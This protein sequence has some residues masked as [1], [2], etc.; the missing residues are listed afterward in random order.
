LCLK[1][2]WDKSHANVHKT[3]PK[4]YPGYFSTDGYN[5][6]SFS[7]EQTKDDAST[8]EQILRWKFEKENQVS[9]GDVQMSSEKQIV[10][11]DTKSILK[12]V[13][14]GKLKL[15]VE[16]LNKAIDKYDFSSEDFMSV[17]LNRVSMAKDF[18]WRA[19]CNWRWAKDNTDQMPMQKRLKLLDCVINDCGFVTGIFINHLLNY[20]K[21]KSSNFIN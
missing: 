4:S 7:S 19:W 11:R 16:L 18:S 15:V 5:H 3:L 2:D 9:F 20:K 14:D 12:A 1:L 8:F 10:V 6:S 21:K 17:M 13:L